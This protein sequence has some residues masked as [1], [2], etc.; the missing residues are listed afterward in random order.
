MVVLVPWK[1]V[2]FVFGLLS[3]LIFLSFFGTAL[4]HGK[5]PFAMNSGIW[6]HAAQ[7]VNSQS[8]PA[9]KS[10]PKARAETAQ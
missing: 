2:V 8:S 5:D 4:I 1:P 6:Q 9:H 3:A 7:H 10:A